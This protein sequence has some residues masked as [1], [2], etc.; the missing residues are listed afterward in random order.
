MK[1]L[2]KATVLLAVISTLA[3]CGEKPSIVIGTCNIDG[4]SNPGNPGDP[5]VL[6]NRNAETEI[7]GWIADVASSKTPEKVTVNLV[8]VDDHVYSFGETN[9]SGIRTDVS[10][11]FAKP[12]DKSGFTVKG[13]VHNITPGLY[14]IQLA[15]IFDDKLGVCVT[16]RKIEIQ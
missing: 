3:A 5:K 16:T 13:G 6:L 15:A 7:T 12:I 14:T 2:V 9:V 11:A 1:N 10:K 8:G 4:I